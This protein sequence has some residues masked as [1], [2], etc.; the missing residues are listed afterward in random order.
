MGCVFTGTDCENNE[1]DGGLTKQELIESLRK[2]REINQAKGLL[3][4]MVCHE[5]QTSL[6]IIQGATDMIEY[7][8]DKLGDL[9]R[10]ITSREIKKQ[11]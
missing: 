1:I 11:F 7:C 9:D 6:A 8:K 10:G 2:E 5:M 4:N 3:V